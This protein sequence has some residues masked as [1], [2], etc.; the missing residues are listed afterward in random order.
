MIEKGSSAT[1]RKKKMAKISWRGGALIAPLPPVMVSCGKDEGKNIVTVAWTGI[2]NTVPPK[3][4]ISLRPSRHS[5]NIIK[6]SGEFVINLTPAS[7]VRAADYCGMYTGAKKDKFKECALTAEPCEVVD[8][9]SIAECPL[10]LECRVTGVKAI[11]THDMFEADIVG[12]R[13]EE[14]LL[15][16]NGKLHI[17][18]ARLAAYAHGEY[19]ELGRRLGSFGFSAVKKGHGRKKHPNAKKQAINKKGSN[20][21]K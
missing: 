18:R 6:E 13:V 7:L 19:F 4:Y 9:V 15:D 14:S 2:I 20:T 11:G 17:E 16:K 3:T 12:V 8:C 5:Y 1:K 10:S 21:E